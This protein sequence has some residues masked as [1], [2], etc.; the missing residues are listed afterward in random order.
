MIWNSVHFL[1]QIEGEIRVI[2]AVLS[3]YGEEGLKLKLVFLT[4]RVF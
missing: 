3:E 1:Q 4:A 2:L